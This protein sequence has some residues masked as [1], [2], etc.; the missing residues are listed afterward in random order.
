MST[1]YYCG[2]CQQNHRYTSKIG[3]KHLKYEEEPPKTETPDQGIKLL[4]TNET[5]FQEETL[6]KH[7]DSDQISNLPDGLDTNLQE[8]PADTEETTEN[9]ESHS[10][11]VIK[12]NEELLD[13]EETTENIDSDGTTVININEDLVEKA[14]SNRIV[15]FIR[16]YQRSYQKGVERFGIWWKVFQ[17]SIWGIVLIFLAIAGII[18]IVYLPKIDMINWTLR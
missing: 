3:Q 1:I 14:H 13:T 9:I 7:E 16:D 18:L 12:I 11:R 17:L 10:F 5:F 15:R 4:D 2:K 6:T 8:E